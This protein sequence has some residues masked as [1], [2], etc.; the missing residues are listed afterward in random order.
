[1]KISTIK[2]QELMSKAIKGVG[3][4]KLI[5]RTTCIAIKVQDNKLTLITSDN[6]N[7][8]VVSEEVESEDFYAV[9]QAEQFSK[10]IM[11]TTSESITMTLDNNI[12]EVHGN[13]T[14]KFPVEIDV[15]T[16][17]MV[18]YPEPHLDIMN[19]QQTSIG[20]IDS[21]TIKTILGAVKPSLAIGNDIP[22]YENYYLGDVVLASDTFKISC[23]NKKVTAAPILMSAR[24]ME[25]LDVYTGEKPLDIY[26]TNGKLLL[27]G[28]NYIVCGCVI[29]DIEKFAVDSILGY[30]NNVYPNKC[31]L[32]KQEL[33]Q[34]LDRLSLF[35]GAFDDGVINIEF[36]T[37]GLHV[38]SQKSDSVEVIPYVSSELTEPMVGRVYLEM[39][40]TQVKAQTTENVELYFGDDTSMKFVDSDIDVVSVVSLVK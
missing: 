14:H 18:Q 17:E 12:V 40:K 30:M 1:M 31:V 11:R 23:L 3:N 4:N 15:N 35:V 7:F 25:L 2:F 8:L 16:L 37:D 10:L 32:P 36:A 21:A 29:A 6:D 24:L 33:I 9:V 26:K 5:S 20:K 28:D 19:T 34:L 27:V 22:P 13:G 39:F 38:S